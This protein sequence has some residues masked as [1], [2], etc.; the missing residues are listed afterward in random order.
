[1]DSLT[2]TTQVLNECA[3]RTLLYY[4]GPRGQGAGSDRDRGAEL[5][6]RGES[7]FPAEGI[8]PARGARA[9]SCN[10]GTL[11]LWQEH[12]RE[13]VAGLYAPTDGR[14]RI[15]GHDIRHL[16]ANELRQ[17]FGV[18]PQETILF[19]GT[20]YE[21]LLMANPQASFE[22]IARACRTAEI[23]DVIER[24]PQGYQTE[25]GER[26]VGLSGGQ[27]QRI[28]IARALLKRPRILVFDEATSSLDSAT[29]EA[30]TATINQ[31]KGRVTMLFI[32]HAVPKNLQVDEIVRI[33][34]GA[35]SALQDR[36]LGSVNGSMGVPA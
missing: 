3:G 7:A 29:A 32:T 33:A 26:G 25:I 8:Q 6:L 18:V 21:N 14:I 12:A 4:P 30:F 15:D 23:H 17:N 19:S 16:A 27:K 31:L 5:S 28:A 2:V 35:P 24:L 13:A 22:Q 1:L 9:R 10:P 34:G 36:A 20:V 11:R